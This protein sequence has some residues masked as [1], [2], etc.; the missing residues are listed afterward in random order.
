MA[1]DESPTIVVIDDVG[2]AVAQQQFQTAVREI[3]AGF[4]IEFL[5]ILQHDADVVGTSLRSIREALNAMPW[6]PICLSLERLTAR[7]GAVVIGDS[8]SHDER[9]V[10][11]LI[12]KPNFTSAEDVVRL[13]GPR[14]YSIEDSCAV[15]GATC[16]HVAAVIRSAGGYV[17]GINIGVS[18]MRAVRSLSLVANAVHC[19]RTYPKLKCVEL[20]NMLL[21]RK[22]YAG[23]GRNVF[24]ENW[25]KWL[26]IIDALPI[27]SRTRQL[28]LQ[29]VREARAAIQECTTFD[30]TD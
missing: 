15:S 30:K 28:A 5:Q 9:G 8:Y 3:S 18:S 14:S 21:N 16:L 11:S 24:P 17:D 19:W 22:T 13:N 1:L 4:L 12:V 20:R 7:K 10:R 25:D 29:L 2:E 23:R 27:T 6:Q 26:S